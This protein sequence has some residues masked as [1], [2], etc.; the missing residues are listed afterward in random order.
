MNYYDSDGYNEILEDYNKNLFNKCD[1]NKPSGVK[2]LNDTYKILFYDV[3]EDNDDVYVASRSGQICHLYKD[4]KLIYEWKSLYHRSRISNLIKHSNGHLYIIFTIDLYGYSVLE[5]DNLKVINYLP[6]E[7][8]TDL[9]ETFIWC[10][11]HY[12]KKNNL[13]AV[14]GCFWAA[15]SSVIILDF[16]NP[17]DIVLAKDFI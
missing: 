9:E 7:S 5:L 1:L 16:S 10:E 15:S 3:E 17:F 6:S 2:R 4:D 14:G 12:N 8:Y 13:L 11:M